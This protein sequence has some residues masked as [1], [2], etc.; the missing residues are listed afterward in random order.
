MT[1]EEFW[2]TYFY[3]VNMIKNEKQIHKLDE[4]LDQIVKKVIKEEQ[5]KEKEGFDEMKDLESSINSFKKQVEETITFSKMKQIPPYSEELERKIL[6]LFGKKKKISV[7]ASELSYNDNIIN[8]VVGIEKPFN[9]VVGL[10]EQ[11]EEL[12]NSKKISKDNEYFS[13]KVLNTKKNDPLLTDF[14]RMEFCRVIPNRFKN[15][16]WTLV[17]STF[18]HG[19]LLSSIYNLM[20]DQGPF[21]LVVKTTN[22]IT[23]GA[24]LACLSLKSKNKYYGGGE[25]FV[26]TFKNKKFEHYHWSNKNE[27]LVY[28]SDSSL[29]IGGGD[30]TKPAIYLDEDF[31]RGSS[32]DCTTFDSPCLVDEKD[33][34]VFAVELWA[35]EFKKE[36]KLKKNKT[37]LSYVNE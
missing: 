3:L 8:Y 6:E 33:F 4:K 32:N 20:E 1:E 21:I 16:D 18:E 19:M 13:P 12:K 27:F 15:R 26:F 23:F 28:S 36:E 34:K 25:T 11:Y 9:E 22:G 17:Y 2:K 7:I 29:Y 24:Y 14:Q 35:F 31:K 37:E 10:I 5:D 30:D